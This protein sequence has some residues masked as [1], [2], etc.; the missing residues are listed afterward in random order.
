MIKYYCNSVQIFA[1]LPVI[2]LE[3]KIKDFSKLFE[4]CLLGLQVLSGGK[5]I[6]T[7]LI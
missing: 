5:V 3:N 4:E 7:Q 6:G 2:K 1:H